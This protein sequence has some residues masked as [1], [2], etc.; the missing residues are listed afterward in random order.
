MN[1]LTWIAIGALVVVSA[2]MRHQLLFLIALILVLLALVSTVWAKY[3]LHGVTY[4]RHFSARRLFFGEEMEMR[5]EVT[6]AKPIPLAWFRAD[7][8]IPAALTAEAA[9]GGVGRRRLVNVLSLRWYEL[10]TRRYPMIGGQRG[11]WRFGPAQLRSGDLF[12]FDIRR[13][14]VERNDYVLV[15][16]KVVP[17]TQ[18]GLPARH[19]F[20]DEKSNLRIFEDPMRLM[21]AREY[22]SGDSFRFVHWKATARRQA[23]QTKVFE[24]SSTRPVAIF[25][26]VSSHEFFN[27]GQD[28]ELMEY[29]ITAAA[30]VGKYVWENGYAVGLYAN[31]W[32]ANLEQQID[33]EAE[34]NG[35]K[36]LR[37]GRVRILPR[38][39]PSQLTYMLEA[40]ARVN[41]RGRWSLEVLLELESRDLPFG[42][43][44][45]IISAVVNRRLQLTLADLQRKGFGVTLITLGE[46]EPRLL[47]P[48]VTTYYI[49]GKERWQ[50]LSTLP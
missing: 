22:S 5:V 33:E 45:V 35:A 42:A 8:E 10:V 19:P 50:T 6:N 16:P 17:I 7:D 23:L 2:V 21:G 12:G 14:T 9:E 4:R 28:W 20:G 48:G 44:L 15:Y 49:G 26:N 3:C 30:S 31:A 47:L 41:E 37:S 1:R 29:A 18:L 32:L 25:L 34:E 43:T 36:A 13:T 38:R 39:S 24:P 40:L 27:E 46:E 11:V